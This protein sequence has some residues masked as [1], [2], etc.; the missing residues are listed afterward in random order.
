MEI[1]MNPIQLMKRLAG[2][3]LGVTILTIVIGWFL[4]PYLKRRKA[5]QSERLDGPQ[6]HLKKEGT[7]TFGGLFFVPSIMICGIADALIWKTNSLL[8]PILYVV[9]IAIVG[10]M[11]DYIKVLVNKE[12][13]SPKQK[14][15]PI[16][17]LA[18]LFVCWYLFVNPFEPVILIPFGGGIVPVRGIGKLFYGIFL[19]VYLYAVSNAVNL[20]DGVD[21]LL[22][23]VSLPVGITLVVTAITVGKALQPLYQETAVLGIFLLGACIGFLLYNRHPAKVFMGDTGSLAIGALI[24]VTA[25]L[26]GVPWLLLLAGIVYV[27]E[28]GSVIIQT[29][30]FRRTGGKRIFRMSPI[31]HHFE[32]GGWSEGKVVGVFSLVSLVGCLLGLLT[33]LPFLH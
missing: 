33:I 12:G 8:M 21:G 11:D 27:A 17:I 24:A 29:T 13:L 31:H 23:T 15:L 25:M 30:Y 2:D 7:P 20:T 26:Q 3:L 32:L 14:S 18:A 9:C 5:S 22:S 19:I 16:L 1:F 6:S 4:L 28:A 10:F